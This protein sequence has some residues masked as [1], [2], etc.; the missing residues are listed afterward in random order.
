MQALA[1]KHRIP[2]NRIGETI[3]IT[4]GRE[5]GVGIPPNA[6]SVIVMLDGDQ[7]INKL[8]HGTDLDIY[9]GAY[10]SNT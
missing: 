9:W 4:T 5:A 2:L 3:H 10:I 8:R 7:A 6:D 1:A